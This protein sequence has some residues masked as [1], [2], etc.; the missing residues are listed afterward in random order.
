MGWG[1]DHIGSS[2]CW[3]LEYP[4]FWT[5]RQALCGLHICPSLHPVQEGGGKGGD[6]GGTSVVS[7]SP[8][9]TLRLGDPCQ[10]K[11]VK[12]EPDS[13][14]IAKL[15]AEAWVGHQGMASQ[16]RRNLG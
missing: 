8:C 12:V 2:V 13:P 9:T 5:S 14:H 6:W 10:S 7:E 15:C 1:E 4:H 3:G 16:G 11:Q